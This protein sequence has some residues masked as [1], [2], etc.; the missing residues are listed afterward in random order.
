M[1]RTGMIDWLYSFREGTKQ[2]REGTKQ[3]REGTNQLK[4]ENERLRKETEALRSITPE[5]IAEI[6]NKSMR[7]DT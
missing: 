7:K 3:I 1:G 4:R 5:K 6:V 2:I